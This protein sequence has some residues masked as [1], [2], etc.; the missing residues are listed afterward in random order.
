MKKLDEIEYIKEQP[1]YAPGPN[2]PVYQGVQKRVYKGTVKSISAGARFGHHLLDIVIISLIQNGINELG[3]IWLVSETG[4]ANHDIDIELY[5]VLST[6][7][8]II[9]VFG[10]L[11]YYFLMEMLFQQTLGKMATQSVVVD[12]YGNKPTAWQFF[13]RTICR[14][15]PFEPFSCLGTPSRGWHD[16]WSKTYVIRRADLAVMKRKLEEQTEEDAA[17]YESMITDESL[18]I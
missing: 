10:G 7:I 12:E 15:V 17:I 5:G 1:T 3:T 2:G 16:K 13:L 14:W 6:L 11:L 18:N 8:W 4:T 9:A